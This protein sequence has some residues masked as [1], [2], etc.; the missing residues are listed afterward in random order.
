MQQ[1]PKPP[2]TDYIQHPI[3]KESPFASLESMLTIILFLSYRKLRNW[4]VLFQSLKAPQVLYSCSQSRSVKKTFLRAQVFSVTIQGFIRDLLLLVR[5]WKKLHSISQ[6]LWKR[7]LARS[8][9]DWESRVRFQL[10]SVLN[11]ESQPFLNCP[12]SPN[13]GK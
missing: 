5:S 10:P 6:H 12:I 4:G 8:A 13:S 2:S 9:P 3:F 7:W 1:F 11:R